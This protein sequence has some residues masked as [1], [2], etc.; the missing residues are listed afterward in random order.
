MFNYRSAPPDEREELY[1]LFPC[2]LN[3]LWCPVYPALE[4]SV[5]NPTNPSGH[6]PHRASCSSSPRLLCLVCVPPRRQQL[7]IRLRPQPPVPLSSRLPNGIMRMVC[8]DPSAPPCLKMIKN[9]A[10][11]GR[12]DLP[13]TKRNQQKKTPPTPQLMRFVTDHRP[14]ENRLLSP[15]GGHGRGDRPPSTPHRSAPRASRRQCSDWSKS[16]RPCGAS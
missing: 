13:E 3:P 6:H 9:A 7:T 2:F 15:T 11:V 12:P 8:F 16:W 4:P 5:P 10:V 14:T 1:H